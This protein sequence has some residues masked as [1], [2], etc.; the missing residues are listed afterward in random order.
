MQLKNDKY[1]YFKKMK[2]N[3]N[4]SKKNTDICNNK[5]EY[6]FRFEHKLNEL[7]YSTIVLVYKFSNQKS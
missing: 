7:V 4:Y 5:M 2:F 1:Q 3:G 6:S